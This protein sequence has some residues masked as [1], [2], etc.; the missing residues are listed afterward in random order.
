[1]DC[2]YTNVWFYAIIVEYDINADSFR[3][4]KWPFTIQYGI[5]FDESS[6]KEDR[7]EVLMVMMIFV[8]V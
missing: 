1:M 8:D 4:F 6:L 2:L 5:C 7:L 3:K